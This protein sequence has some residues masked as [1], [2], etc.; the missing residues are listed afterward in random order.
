M[1]ADD[2]EGQKQEHAVELT[3]DDDNACGT[4]YLSVQHVHLPSSP[5]DKDGE[6]A[7]FVNK[8][9]NLKEYAK[10]VTTVEQDKWM[11]VKAM[12]AIVSYMI[13]AGLFYTNVEC[14]DERSL[15]E[16]S[17]SLSSST[18][19]HATCPDGMY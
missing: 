8:A 9:E 19:A 14:C 13:L 10:D 4:L 5:P 2:E 3:D 1:A 11:W 12:G 7:V 18:P 6:L 17:C 16:M 15:P